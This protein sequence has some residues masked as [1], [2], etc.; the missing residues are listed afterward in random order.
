M[1]R[2][3]R[4][5]GEWLAPDRG[6]YLTYEEIGVHA[7]RYTVL[8]HL[9][10]LY[11]SPSNYLVQPTVGW[12][13][14]T[15]CDAVEPVPTTATVFPVRSCSCSHRAVWKLSLIHISEPTRPY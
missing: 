1:V 3:G 5:W 7:S 4:Y 14:G 12:I 11:V 10:K 13:A 2:G 9:T 6:C 8:G 15:T